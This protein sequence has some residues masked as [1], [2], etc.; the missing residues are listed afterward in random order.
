MTIAPRQRNSAAHAGSTLGLL[1]LLTA[2]VA[3]TATLVFTGGAL[4]AVLALLLWIGL[5][6]IGVPGLLALLGL[7]FSTVG[8]VRSTAS[9]ERI[10]AVRG[11][12]FSLVAFV[13]PPVTWIV[14]AAVGLSTAGR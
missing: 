5:L 14:I 2:V 3:I 13:V 4:I 8:I 9:G 6:V 10:V 1:A 11:L 12:A 7:I